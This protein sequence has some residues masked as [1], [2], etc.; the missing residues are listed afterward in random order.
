MVQTAEQ[1]K[2]A[3]KQTRNKP[4][5]MKNERGVVLVL[6]LVM[7]LVLGVIGALSISTSTTELRIAGNYRN[8]M[9]GYY[10]ANVADA[11]GPGN[12][13]INKVIN[14]YGFPQ[15]RTMPDAAGNCP[16]PMISRNTLGNPNFPIFNF[17]EQQLMPAGFIGSVWVRVE[18]L[19]MS[20][21][22][23]GKAN[24][25]A[26]FMEF[27]YLVTMIGKDATNAEHVTETEV[28]Q[29]GQQPPG[30]DQDC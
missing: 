23:P 18:Y 22:S 14:P 12:I 13:D 7:L 15:V 25:A 6:A 17:C 5:P 20:A 8:S 3:W 24:D 26:N 11:F 29:V 28:I 21:M 16:A 9:I 4:Y 10:N 2:K 19:C 30:V 1:R 27:H